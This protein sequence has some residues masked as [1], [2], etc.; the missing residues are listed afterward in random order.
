MTHETAPATTMAI[1]VVR[2]WRETSD[3]EPRWRGQIE[4]VQ[5]GQSEGFLDLNGMLRCLRHFGVDAGIA[6]LSA[7]DDV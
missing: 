6:R 4:H 7:A 1:F 5:S 2:F 3:G